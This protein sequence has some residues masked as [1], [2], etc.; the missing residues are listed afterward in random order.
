ML[1]EVNREEWKQAQKL[2]NKGKKKEKGGTM[3]ATE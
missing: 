3:D 1:V 2:K